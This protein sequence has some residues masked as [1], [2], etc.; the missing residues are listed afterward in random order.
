MSDSVQ[1]H[2]LQPTRLPRPWDS[3]GKNTEV[4]CH[5]LLQC[6]KVKS[7]SEVAQSCPTLSDPIVCILPGSS[8]HGI[9]QARVLQWVAIAFSAKNTYIPW[10]LPPSPIGPS[11]FLCSICLLPTYMPSS[12]THGGQHPYHPSTLSSLLLL[13]PHTLLRLANDSH[14]GLWNILI[15]KPILLIHT[16]LFKNR[17]SLLYRELSLV[18]LVVT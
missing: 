4:G 1:P 7:E 8:I 5:C 9:F 3:P 14:Y 6:M 10:I 15:W 18:L 11:P 17:S 13:N 12:P 16:P 2:R